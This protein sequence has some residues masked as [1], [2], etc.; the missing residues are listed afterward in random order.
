MATTD[1]L[2]IATQRPIRMSVTGQGHGWGRDPWKWVS[3]LSR[4]DR[5]ALRRGE[6]VVIG[7]CPPAGGT[8][9][10]TYREARIE[11]GRYVHRMPDAG[12]LAR[13]GAGDFYGSTD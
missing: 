10:P 11:V 1:P 12:T 5:N 13:I 8:H 6:I 9:G 7:D 3:R 4:G 2:E